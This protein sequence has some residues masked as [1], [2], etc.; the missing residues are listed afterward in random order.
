MD[1]QTQKDARLAIA[2]QADAIMGFEGHR[3]SLEERNIVRKWVA[4]EIDDEILSRLINDYARSL[5]N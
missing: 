1:A 3:P 2:R 4:G 5:I